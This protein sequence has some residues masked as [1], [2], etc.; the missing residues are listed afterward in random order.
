MEYITSSCNVKRKSFKYESMIE[1]LKEIWNKLDINE[2]KYL[3]T[4]IQLI[5]YCTLF[6]VII[7]P[8][9]L[10]R[11][12]IS[13]I[14]YKNTGAIGDTING[15]AGPFIALLA[16]ILT[17][18]AFYIQYKANIEQRTQF[19][20][21]ILRQDK[22]SSKQEIELIRDRIESRFF[23]LLKLH[24][25]NINEFKSKGNSGK[26]VVIAMYDEFN[27]LFDSIKYW[28]TFEKSGLYYQHEWHRKVAQ[29]AYDIM[30]FGLANNSTQD[31]MMRIQYTVANDKFFTSEFYPMLLKNAIKHHENI[32][33]ENIGKSKLQRTYLPNDGHQ[34]RLGHY[35]RHLYQTVKFIDEQPSHILNYD[36]KYF[37]IKTLRAQMTT[38]EQALFFYNSLTIMGQS[39]ELSIEIPNKKLITKYNLIKNIPNGFTGDLIPGQFYPNVNYE[40][41]VNPTFERKEI[42]KHYS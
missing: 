1:T 40:F 38:H 11:E 12:T 33:T 6:F 14:D 29:I 26:S 8:W 13:I 28:Y 2:K 15:I 19:N 5:I 21:T 30:F 24:R 31:L 10:T 41:I 7:I 37:Y 9:L 25:A 34:S 36:E 32:K 4:G 22:E 39:W 18:L 27:K 23:E 42:E 35:F 20:K 16:A 17:F 3:K